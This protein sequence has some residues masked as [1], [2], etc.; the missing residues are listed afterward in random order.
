MS[1]EYEGITYQATTPTKAIRAKC[2]DCSGGSVSEVRK[3]AAK[4]CPL[5]PFRMG[6]N[7]FLKN[8]ERMSDEEKR[9][10]AKRLGT[11]KNFERNKTEEEQAFWDIGEDTEDSCDTD[12]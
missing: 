4:V 1:Q 2:L 5:F 10:L 3:C 12:T 9:E 6:Y 8:R 7:G 11:S